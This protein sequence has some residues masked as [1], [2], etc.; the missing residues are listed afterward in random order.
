M[1]RTADLARLR[2]FFHAL[3]GALLDAAPG[4]VEIPRVVLLSPGTASETAYDQ[5][6]LASMLGFPLAEADD[7]VVSKG[8]VWLRA[9]DDLEPVDVILRRVEAALSDPLEFRGN[10]EVGLPG[11]VETARQG[12]VTIANPVGA[13]VLDNPALIAYLRPV[14]Q[15][16]LG[17]EPL[18]KSPKTWWC[19]DP[20]Q[21][22]HVLAG[23]DRLVVKPVTRSGGSPVRYGWLL[24]A[25]EREDLARQIRYE[26]WAWC[27]QEPIELST[28]PVVTRRAG[29]APVPCCGR[30]G[31]PWTTGT[32]SCPA[33][34]AGWL[35][36]SPSTRC[37]ARPGPSPRTSGCR[38]RRR[39][40]TSRPSGPGGHW[41]W[42]LGSRRC[43]HG[44]RTC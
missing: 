34:L 20:A 16:L 30:S 29:A 37:P 3:T 31:S 8:R 41:S 32:A 22:A 36:G 2:N 12:A 11:M 42:L 1:H 44:W 9:G 21:A 28:A 18:L 19:G 39:T 33:A 40:V 15:A 27:G 7:L 4:E 17:E 35:R 10:S 14:A 5:G 23:L 38:P 26:P 13:G 6:F 43:R 24:S 25:A